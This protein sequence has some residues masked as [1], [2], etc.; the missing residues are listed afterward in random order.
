MHVARATRQQLCRRKPDALLRQPGVRLRGGVDLTLVIGKPVR[1]RSHGLHA[2]IAGCHKSRCRVA[3]RRSLLVLCQRH[4]TQ[5]AVLPPRALRL[6]LQAMLR[7]ASAKLSAARFERWLANL[8]WQQAIRLAARDPSNQ[9]L[10]EAAVPAVGRAS[11][12]R[13]RMI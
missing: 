5:S 6:P 4:A 8:L 3:V 12:S 2:A 10:E 9:L 13:A 7:L 11:G 1:Q